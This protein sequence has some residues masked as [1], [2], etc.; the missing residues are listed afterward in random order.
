MEWQCCHADGRLEHRPQS[1][2][3]CGVEIVSQLQRIVK[4]KRSNSISKLLQ[5]ALVG[6]MLD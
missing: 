1:Y 3:F 4:S 6:T 2:F 5:L